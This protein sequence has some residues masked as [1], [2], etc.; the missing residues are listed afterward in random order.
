MTAETR[1]LIAKEIRHDM[2]RWNAAVRWLLQQPEG[3]MRREAFQHANFWRNVLRDADHRLQ[4]LPAD[5]GRVGPIAMN[6]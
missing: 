4:T 1:R 6:A 5:E 3:S 2:E